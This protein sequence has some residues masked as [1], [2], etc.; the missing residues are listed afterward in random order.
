MD[1][2]KVLDE[3]K[4]SKVE[5]YYGKMGPEEAYKTVFDYMERHH[6]WMQ[7]CIHLIASENIPSPAVREAIATD[8]G[9][10]Y[11]E[12]WPGERVY[13]GCTYID[14]VEVLCSALAKKLFRA[15]FADVR[16]I[17]GVVANL[18]VYATFTNPGDRIMA[19]SIPSGGHISMGRK[20]NWGTAGAVRGLKV[21]AFPFDEE[22]F[23][24]DVDKTRKLVEKLAQKDRRVQLY[25]LGGSVFIFPAPVK[26][27]VEIAR[28][29]DAFVNYD[30]AHI[31][32][33]IAGGEFQDPL[34]EGVDSMSCST[35]KTF[36]GPQHGM[37]LSKT[38]HAD[39]I[40]KATFPGMTSNHHLHNVA[41]TAVALAEF[42]KFGDPY[43]KQIIKNAQKLGQAL[44][45]RGFNVLAEHKGFTKSHTLWIDV[46]KTP[47]KYGS[48]IEEELERSNII[49]NRNLL[50]WD[51]REGRDY[52]KPGG[53]RLGTSEITR[54]GMKENEMDQVAEYISRVV[55]K[56]EDT[57]NVAKDVAEFKKDFSKIHFAFDTAK[58]AYAYIKMR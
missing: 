27:V 53:I 5:E 25:M 29:H 31:S 54:L 21:R 13:A 52:K 33:L 19:L 12:G 7:D 28:E 23:V 51:N 35:H 56:G 3:G 39:T 47:M 16:P 38:E 55:I 15:E 11:A 50:P 17:S 46:T 20:A 22:N 14:Q 9:D 36:P 44:H 45:E 4:H 1:P 30:A 41:G 37:V 43:V 24:I 6:K 2:F 34:R 42:L 57:T 40:K 32:G 48:V 18:V 10:R 8:F 58:D 26:E 49:I